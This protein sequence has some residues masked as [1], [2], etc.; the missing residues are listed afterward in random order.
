MRSIGRQGWGCPACAERSCRAVLKSRTETEICHRSERHS[1]TITTTNDAIHT[2][3]QDLFLRHSGG[4][5]GELPARGGAGRDVLLQC[6]LPLSL[7]RA[8]CD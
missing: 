6:P 3:A 5:G 7:G 8:F 2:Q 4:V 1:G